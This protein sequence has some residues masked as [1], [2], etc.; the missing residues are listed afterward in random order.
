MC[1]TWFSC[2]VA[3]GM[4]MGRAAGSFGALLE[5]LNCWSRRERVLQELGRVTSAWLE[6]IRPDQ[7][8]HAAALRSARWVHAVGRGG[9]AVWIGLT[10]RRHCAEECVSVC[11]GPFPRIR[12][13]SLSKQEFVIG[14]FPPSYVI[15]THT[16][17]SRMAGSTTAR[18]A[19]KRV[20]DLGRAGSEPSNFDKVAIGIA[21]LLG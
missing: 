14:S 17:S 18:L 16:K 4:G 13:I 3:E 7:V 15:C 2:K 19:R 5:C 11:S 6:A 9:S 21:R 20:I 10:S 1:D 8:R 12:I